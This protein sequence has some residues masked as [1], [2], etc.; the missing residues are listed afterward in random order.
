MSRG[1]LPHNSII[2]FVS[3]ARG[4][5]CIF[6]K[7]EFDVRISTKVVQP[8]NRSSMAWIGGIKSTH[9]M[10]F[11]YSTMENFSLVYDYMYA[12][13]INDNLNFSVFICKTKRGHSWSIP[14]FMLYLY[15]HHSI[16]VY[17]PTF[18]Y[19]VWDLASVS[20]K[21]ILST[22]SFEAIGLGLVQQRH[23]LISTSWM[24]AVMYHR[25]FVLGCSLLTVLVC[26]LFWFSTMFR[27]GLRI[28]GY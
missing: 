28:T 10:S 21:G 17:H 16:Y 18:K 23:N 27:C 13:I 11:V 26:Y 15:H 19:T 2:A 1:T 24:T 12:Y 4:F 14:W 5:F 8:F 22:Y 9:S 25:T 7:H 3:R 6:F 20:G